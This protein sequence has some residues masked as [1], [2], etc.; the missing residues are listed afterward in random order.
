M[1]RVWRDWRGGRGHRSSNRLS[2]RRRGRRGRSDFRGHG[3]LR[4][5]RL[6]RGLR[7]GGDARKITV[8]HDVY[9][10]FG[11]SE[12]EPHINHFSVKGIRRGRA[13]ATGSNG[14]II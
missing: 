3:F 12:F 4:N 2:D 10:I 8:A 5:P 14:A 1:G 7:R 6:R 9:L 13:L 11:L